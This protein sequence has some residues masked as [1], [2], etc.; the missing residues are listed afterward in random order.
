MQ[1][2]RRT[3]K[4]APRK[5][6]PLRASAVRALLD[7]SGTTRLIDLRDTRCWS[8]WHWRCAARNWRL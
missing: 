7:T 3:Q 6:N 8:G 5:A 1:G 2:I 4:T